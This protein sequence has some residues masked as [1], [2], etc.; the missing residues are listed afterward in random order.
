MTRGDGVQERSRSCTNP[1]PQF[2]GNGCAGS[3]TDNKVCVMP[4][5]PGSILKIFKAIQVGNG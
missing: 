2:D 4:Y 1:V 5:C 3:E